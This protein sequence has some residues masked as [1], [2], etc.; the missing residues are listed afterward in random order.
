MAEFKSKMF[1]VIPLTVIGLSWLLFNISLEKCIRDSGLQRTKTILTNSVQLL[2]FAYDVD[3][4]ARSAFLTLERRAKEMDW[5]VNAKKTK[6]MTTDK[7]NYNKTEICINRYTFE[8][9]DHFRHLG[10]IVA[11]N[12]T[13]P[14]T[15]KRNTKWNM[16]TTH[17]PSPK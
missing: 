7:N 3:I 2:A 4:I 14:D 16:D 11:T 12:K 1:W 13:S 17:G 9:V 5:V 15:R 6:Y 8:R 10:S